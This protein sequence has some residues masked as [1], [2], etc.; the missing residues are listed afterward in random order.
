MQGNQLSSFDFYNFD[1]RDKILTTFLTFLGPYIVAGV[2]KAA[3]DYC[4]HFEVE[5]RTKLAET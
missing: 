4:I 3:A 2:L 5:L 1:E